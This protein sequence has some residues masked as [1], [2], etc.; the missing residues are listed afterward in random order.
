MEEI[1]TESA[2]ELKTRIILNFGNLLDFLNVRF[3]IENLDYYEFSFHK[4]NYEHVIGEL[5]SKFGQDMKYNITITSTPLYKSE[6]IPVKFY[7][8][9][10]KFND[11]LFRSKQ[12]YKVVRIS[13]PS[14]KIIFINQQNN[15]VYC[16]PC[17]N[18]ETAGWIYGL[19]NWKDNEPAVRPEPNIIK[20]QN[21]IT[22]T[23]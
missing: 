22:I 13:D 2:S 11:I 6:I 15:D 14:R 1:R 12:Y 4:L 9:E 19:L 10:N 20:I 3:N 5:V 8:H 23:D 17:N 21:T 18:N 16:D 7:F